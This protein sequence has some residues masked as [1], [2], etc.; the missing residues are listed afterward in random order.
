MQGLLTPPPLPKNPRP[1]PYK[2][3]ALL[4]TYENDFYGPLEVVQTGNDLTVVAGPL[5]YAA[6]LK[7]INAGLY[8][9]KWPGVTMGPME[10]LFTIG[11]DG[12]ATTMLVGGMGSFERK[13]P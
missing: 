5:R 8:W 11:E 3:E 4:G 6:T 10:T 7:H 1:S 9:L 13:T 12:T 2:P